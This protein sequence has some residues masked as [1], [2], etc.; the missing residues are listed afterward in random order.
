MPWDKQAPGKRRGPNV[1]W[2]PDDGDVYV[3]LG[4]TQ[5][6]LR[7]STRGLSCKCNDETASIGAS[8]TFSRGTATRCQIGAPWAFLRYQLSPARGPER[9]AKMRGKGQGPRT[10]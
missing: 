9:S 3:V 7:W 1:I 2:G 10:D 5:T 4:V 6:A 8:T